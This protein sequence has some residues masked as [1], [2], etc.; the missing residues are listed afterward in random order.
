MPES[1][2][3][4]QQQQLDIN[5]L[6]Y[7]KN[8]REHGPHSVRRADH[9]KGP[10]PMLSWIMAHSGLDQ[11]VDKD[12]RQDHVAKWSEPGDVIID[13]HCLQGFAIAWGEQ[14]GFFL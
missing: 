5:L 10:S 3:L 8:L 12:T 6:E 7:D 11:G 14:Y 13:R 2:Y 1:R 4:L 9:A